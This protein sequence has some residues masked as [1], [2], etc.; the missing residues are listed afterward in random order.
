M[1]TENYFSLYSLLT[2]TI[3]LLDK[4]LNGQKRPRFKREAGS[5]KQNSIT[6]T[7]TAATKVMHKTLNTVSPNS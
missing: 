5:L 2:S 1:N 7:V 6:L 4:R 3:K